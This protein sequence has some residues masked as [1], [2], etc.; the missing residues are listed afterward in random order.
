[1][2]LNMKIKFQI[3]YEKF[4]FNLFDFIILDLSAFT[5][6]AKKFKL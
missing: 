3:Y 2:S 1:M 6:F 4:L 5:N